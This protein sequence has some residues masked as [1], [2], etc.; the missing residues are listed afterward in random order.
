M[1]HRPEHLFTWI[2]HG[3]LATNILHPYLDPNSDWLKRKIRKSVA[4]NHVIILSMCICNVLARTG[5][6]NRI[7]VVSHLTSSHSCLPQ[8]HRVSSAQICLLEPARLQLGSGYKGSSLMVR[9]VAPDHVLGCIG[10]RSFASDLP[11][12][13]RRRRGPGYWHKIP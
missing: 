12:S 5:C 2:Q 8:E 7:E 11:L 3:S 6:Y 10:G 1:Q 13:R 9:R 4:H